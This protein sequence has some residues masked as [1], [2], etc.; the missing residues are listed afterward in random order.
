M[1]HP[2][3]QLLHFSHISQHVWHK[4]TLS[5][6]LYLWNWHQNMCSVKHDSSEGGRNAY[7]TSVVK[8]NAGNRLGDVGNV[9]ADN[10][11]D[12]KEAGWEGMG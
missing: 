2:I 5:H 10:M 12:L 7:R 6:E 11:M 3:Q 1:P 9:R 4:S 8:L